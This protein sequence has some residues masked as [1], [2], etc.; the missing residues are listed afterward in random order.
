MTVLLE[1]GNISRFDSVGDFSSYARC[2]ESKCISNNKKKGQNNR[3]CG[4]RYLSWAFHEAAHHSLAHYPPIKVF[5]ERKKRKTNGMIA[6][7]AVAHKLPR[8]CFHVLKKREAFNMALAF[9]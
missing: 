3:K 7:R 9:Q 1:I 2:V 6:I 4:N 5:Y 8:A